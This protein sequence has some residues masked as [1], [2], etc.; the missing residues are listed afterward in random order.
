MVGGE[1]E[2]KISSLIKEEESFL[3]SGIFNVKGF[4]LLRLVFRVGRSRVL[5]FGIW[6]FGLKNF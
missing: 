5:K 4:V 6:R 3:E 2:L 1:R